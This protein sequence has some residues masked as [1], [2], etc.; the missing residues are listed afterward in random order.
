MQREGGGVIISK[1]DSRG[2]YICEP[3]RISE[4]QVDIIFFIKDNDI[5]TDDKIPDKVTKAPENSSGETLFQTWYTLRH[6]LVEKHE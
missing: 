3:V 5:S 1:A 4:I 6:A 2:R